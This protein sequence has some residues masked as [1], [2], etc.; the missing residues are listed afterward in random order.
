MS[1][2]GNNCTEVMVLRNRLPT[3]PQISGFEFSKLD[4][5]LTAG[6][7]VLSESITHNQLLNNGVLRG[8][9][10]DVDPCRRRI[11]KTDII[12]ILE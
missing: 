4:R 8:S 2:Y 5:E 1:N 11:T 6:T 10:V 7:Y 12:Q 3:N 9:R